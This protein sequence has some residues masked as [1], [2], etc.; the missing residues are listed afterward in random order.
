MTGFDFNI[1]KPQDMNKIAKLQYSNIVSE[2]KSIFKFMNN[3]TQKVRLLGLVI[4]NYKVNS[5][6]DFKQL[7][8]LFNQKDY[9]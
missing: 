5:D 1:H 6:K 9:P 3:E 8:S 7:C 4:I 2:V